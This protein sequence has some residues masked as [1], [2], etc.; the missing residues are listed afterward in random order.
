MKTRLL[1]PLCLFTPL[2]HAQEEEPALAPE[3]L[4]LDLFFDTTIFGYGQKRL[5]GHRN[6]CLS[7]RHDL[8]FHGI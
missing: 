3:K 2:L 8:L 6:V 5:P 4:T 1:L 7:Q